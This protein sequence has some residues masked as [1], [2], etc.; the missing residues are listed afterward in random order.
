MY[1]KFNV[2]MYLYLYKYGLKTVPEKVSIKY[3]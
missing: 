3:K 2:F 1:E